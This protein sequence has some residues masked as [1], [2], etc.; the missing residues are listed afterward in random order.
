M[1]QPG[2]TAV[3]TAVTVDS[4]REVVG[5]LG[6]DGADGA[7]WVQLVSTMDGKLPRTIIASPAL[8][9]PNVIPWSGI[10]GAKVPGHA[11]GPKDVVFRQVSVLANCILSTGSKKLDHW[12]TGCSLWQRTA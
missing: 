11:S 12:C 4:D 10:L 9:A 3:T 2:A 8:A 7:I 5:L 6:R 1:W